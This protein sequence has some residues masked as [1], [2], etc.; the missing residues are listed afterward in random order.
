MIKI[1]IW[2]WGTMTVLLALSALIVVVWAGLWID[3]KP[4][5]DPK[6]YTFKLGTPEALGGIFFALKENGSL[7]AGILGFSDL[8]WAQ[9]FQA[10]KK[11]KHKMAA[12][13]EPKDDQQDG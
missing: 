1:G 9:F 12:T 11:A 3:I 13:V 5:G 2:I 10:E 4:G 7:V 6:L 8:A